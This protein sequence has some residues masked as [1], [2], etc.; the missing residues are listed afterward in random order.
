MRVYTN[1]SENPLFSAITTNETNI[2]FREYHVYLF[3]F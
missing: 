1:M 3:E 2:L